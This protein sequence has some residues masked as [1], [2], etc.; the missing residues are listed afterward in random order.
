MAFTRAF[1][2]AIYQ[3][4]LEAANAVDASPA[5][6]SPTLS[7][8][9]AGPTADGPVKSTYSGSG[10][11]SGSGGL[12]KAIS[13]AVSPAPAPWASS[14]AN[15]DS[16]AASSDSSVNP[17][18]GV[19]DVGGGVSAGVGKGEASDVKIV[20]KNLVDLVTFADMELS[21]LHVA[22]EDDLIDLKS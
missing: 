6:S 10:S 1:L 12:P 20:R 7:S 13:S 15:G 19:G 22:T 2:G 16:H 4:E 18:M 8:I 17:M 11:G 3:S 21:P 5:H 14:I 9:P